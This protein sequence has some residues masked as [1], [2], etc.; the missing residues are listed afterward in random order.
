MAYR[1]IE[2]NKYNFPDVNNHVSKDYGLND[3]I[4]I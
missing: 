2:Y 4:R 3:D 1:S